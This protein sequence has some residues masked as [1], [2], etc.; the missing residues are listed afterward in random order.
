MT[1]QELID[2]YADLLIIQYIGKDNA[3]ATIQALVT[4]VIMNQLP[5]QVMNAFNVT[6]DDT[7]V[8]DQ[9]DIL[10]K[11]VGV[12]RTGYNFSEAITLD[13]AD[14][15]SL[16]RIAIVQNNN[17][18]SLYDIEALLDEFFPDQIFTFDYQDM[19]MGY[20]IDTTV[21]SLDLIEL[22]VIEGLLP[23]P[24]AVLLRYVIYVPFPTTLFG[25]RNYLY[26]NTNATPF[27]LYT[28]YNTDWKWLSYANGIAP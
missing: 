22:F 19:T 24:M 27:N 11:Y 1:D 23:K 5:T 28:D 21:G 14:F 4:P 16:I 26:A 3:Y 2:Y 17:G 13:D 6:G 15:L 18:S 8:G 12:T 10:G 9:L 25:F 7:A 20:I